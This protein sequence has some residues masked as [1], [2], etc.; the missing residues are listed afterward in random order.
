[1]PQT[2]FLIFNSHWTGLAKGPQKE[3]NSL[4]EASNK[5][6]LLIVSPVY[7][8]ATGIAE[9]I[10]SVAT[11]RLNLTPHVEIRLLLV[12]DGSTDNSDHIIRRQMQTQSWISIKNLLGNYG[13]QAALVAGLESVEDWADLVV[14]MDSDLEHPVEVIIEMLRQYESDSRCILVQGVR[15]AHESL[16]L[17]KRLL[18]KLF[19]RA[20]SATTGLKLKD[21]QGDFCL[22]NAK[23]IRSLK[24]YL[25]SIGSLRVFAAWV[26]GVKFYIPYKQKLRKHDSSKYTITQNWNLTLNSVVR[27]SSMPLRMITW[28]GLLGVAISLI[29]LVQI[30]LAIYHH[31]PVQAG[32]TTLIVTII[33][34]SCLQ[35][36]CLGILAEYFRR[37]VFGRDLPLFLGEKVMSGRPLA[38][39]ESD[40]EPVKLEQQ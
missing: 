24:P 40:Y 15:E 29:H 28:L 18:S 25:K 11:L 32:W 17:G 35:L 7:N 3:G 33:F 22:W 2:P 37:L 23:L 39:S 31:E 36:I 16:S 9:F 27:F 8:E 6:K 14:T 12:N 21:G 34:M 13:H 1:L 5:L 19:Y 10:R 30:A 4:A 20:V 26:P 38:V